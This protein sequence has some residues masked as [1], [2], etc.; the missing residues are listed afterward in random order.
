VL[1]EIVGQSEWSERADYKDFAARLR[2]RAKLTNELDAA[3][4]VRTTAEW[5]GLFAGR[6]PAAPIHDVKA[7]L[8]SAFVHDEGR[9]RTATRPDGSE[10]RLLAP[11]IRS[12]GEE[13]PCK[14]AP[15]LGSDTDDVLTQ[16]GYARNEI[17]RLRAA[18]AL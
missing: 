10:V 11:P 2:N 3:L 12:P 16:L 13:A 14:A 4:S 5:I 7:A 8:D 17:A 18:G 6:V 15:S 9:V 1:C